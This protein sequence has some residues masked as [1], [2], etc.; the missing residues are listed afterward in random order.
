MNHM[1]SVTARGE[2]IGEVPG[3]HRQRV[4]DAQHVKQRVHGQQL[5]SERRKILCLVS[6]APTM[7]IL[8]ACFHSD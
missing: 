8:I 7:T 4:I 6:S 2:V 3:A 5:P 1:E